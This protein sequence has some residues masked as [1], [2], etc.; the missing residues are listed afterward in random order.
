MHTN[1][2]TQ[3]P[4]AFLTTNNDVSETEVRETGPFPTTPQN[5]SHKQ[6]KVLNT[7]QQKP[8]S[9]TEESVEDTRQQK[10]MCSQAGR[11]NTVTSLLAKQSSHAMQSSSKPSWH[12]SQ[13]EKNS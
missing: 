2:N 10:P 6:P 5:N 7:L 13:E 4:A 1:T 11:I 9:E 8:S 3:A 12:S